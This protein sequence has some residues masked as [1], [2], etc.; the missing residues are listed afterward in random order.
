LRFIGHLLPARQEDRFGSEQSQSAAR[1]RFFCRDLLRKA[2]L[3]PI[4]ERRHGKTG[5]LS[6]IAIAVLRDI[7]SQAQLEAPILWLTR[8]SF[9][10]MALPSFVIIVFRSGIG[11]RIR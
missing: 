6:G 4:K 1:R 3:K 9:S 5:M 10:V 2:Q 8:Q 7:K 11:C